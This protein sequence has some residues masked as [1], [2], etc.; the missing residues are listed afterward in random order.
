MQA[1]YGARWSSQFKSK[2]MLH[3]AKVEWILSLE[4]FS[5]V[6]IFM[7]LEKIKKVYLSPPSLPEFIATLN[8]DKPTLPVFKK[9]KDETSR[10]DRINCAGYLKF[11]RVM[12][13][14][15]IN[16]TVPTGGASES[17][18]DP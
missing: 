10:E 4:N 3:V 18:S 14:I 11:K 16:L 15:G 5:N 1:I 17:S 9:I 2:E 12:E 6:E 7:A 8:S 13:R